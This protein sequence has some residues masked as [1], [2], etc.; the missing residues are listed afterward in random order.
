MLQA[1]RAP[2][3]SAPKA[4]CTTTATATIVDAD[5]IAG[6]H[7]NAATAIG[8]PPEGSK[9]RPATADASATVPTVE[10]LASI[11][12][13]TL[14]NGSAPFRVGDVITYSFR[15]VNTGTLTLA[16]VTISD[17]TL[18]IRAAPCVVRLAPGESALCA[19]TGQHTVT[20]ADAAAGTLRS[21]A[22][23]TGETPP[24]FTGNNTVFA[25]DL[26]TLAIDPN[27]GL[28][29]TGVSGPGT[30]LLVALGLILLGL[31]TLILERRRRPQTG[32]WTQ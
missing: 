19:T 27:T 8:Q 26:L 15:V 30:A 24:G 6:H 16:R 29:R 9:L 18:G 13:T 23:A 1:W 28:A 31:V 10:A 14:A 20:A 21:S 2:P 22:T 7:D 11:A 32:P 12:L 4:L 25:E 17:A 5:V 3:S